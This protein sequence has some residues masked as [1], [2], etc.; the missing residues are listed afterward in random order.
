[1]NLI[2]W[3]KV[4]QGHGEVSMLPKMSIEIIDSDSFSH[5]LKVLLIEEL[6]QS[7][8]T[9]NRG[10][11]NHSLIRGVKTLKSNLCI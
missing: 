2:L 4:H 6:L 8:S 11:L 3:R 10:I 9:T 1:M 5:L 7:K